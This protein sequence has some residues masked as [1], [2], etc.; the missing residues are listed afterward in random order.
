MRHWNS[1]DHDYA[2]EDRVKKGAE[3]IKQG[4]I[5]EVREEI[6]WNKECDRGTKGMAKT[7]DYLFK[8]L[9]IGDSGVGKTC[10]LFRFSEDAFNTTF[11]STIGKYI[12]FSF[13]F[14]NSIFLSYFYSSSFVYRFSSSSIY[15]FNEYQ[16]ITHQIF[17]YNWKINYQENISLNNIYYLTNVNLV[18]YLFLFKDIFF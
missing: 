7:Y 4:N 18:V 10:V 16:W 3:R 12:L 8:L 13:L 11:I 14:L 2:R 15:F 5:K 9:L 1:K 17:I 6:T